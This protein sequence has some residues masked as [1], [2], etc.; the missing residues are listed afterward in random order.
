MASYNL[1]W[2]QVVGGNKIRLLDTGSMS[3]LIRLLKDSANQQPSFLLLIG[4]HVKD[5]VVQ[6]LFPDNNF[7]EHWSNGVTSLRVDDTSICSDNPLF[8]AESNPRRFIS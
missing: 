6:Q 4:A 3:Q 1:P 2:L 8:F 7:R 5:R